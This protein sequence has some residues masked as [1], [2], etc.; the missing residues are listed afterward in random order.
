MNFN[1]LR[2]GIVC[3]SIWDVMTIDLILNLNNI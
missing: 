3:G 2:G 1:L